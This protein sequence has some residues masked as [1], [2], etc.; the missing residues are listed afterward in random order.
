MNPVMYLA[1]VTSKAGFS[2]FAPFGPM[3]WL[4]ILNTSFWDLSS[5]GIPF[6]EEIRGSNVLMGAA[7]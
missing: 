2:A 5:I 1:G 3:D 6:S 4:P 7:T